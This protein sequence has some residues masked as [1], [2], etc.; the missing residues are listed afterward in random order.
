MEVVRAASLC[1]RKQSHSF[2]AADYVGRC[3]LRETGET[4]KTPD[5][6]LLL[7]EGKRMQMHYLWYGHFPFNVF[8]AS[9]V[10]WQPRVCADQ[11]AFDFAAFIWFLEHTEPNQTIPTKSLTFKSTEISAL[12]C[13]I[14]LWEEQV[15][16]ILGVSGT[17]CL[18]LDP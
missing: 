12:F 5:T 10:S 7:Q 14:G 18:V 11:F 13:C 8:L 16:C 3:T 1:S 9:D 17:R 15:H 4:F 2:R 6:S